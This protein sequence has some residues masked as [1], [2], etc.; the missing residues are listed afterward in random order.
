MFK[1]Y[2]SKSKFITVHSE[3]HKI[4][5]TVVPLETIG[6]MR[7]TYAQYECPVSCSK[8]V[9]TDVQKKVKGRN[10]GHAFKIVIDRLCHKE[11]ISQI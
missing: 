10:Q 6:T 2:K 11:H 8:R 9:M 1:L 5:G 3:G 7:N 4:Y